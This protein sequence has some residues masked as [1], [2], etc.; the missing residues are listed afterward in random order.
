MDIFDT[1]PYLGL[2]PRGA[3][4]FAA[5]LVLSAL[6]LI[7]A[8]RIWFLDQAQKHEQHIV[9]PIIQR[10]LDSLTRT[11]TSPSPQ[12]AHHLDRPAAPARVHARP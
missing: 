4:R 3:K 2:L 12:P 10:Y 7:P 1:E 6:M 9:M 5:L 11:T 8:S